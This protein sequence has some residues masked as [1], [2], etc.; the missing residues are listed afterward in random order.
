MADA[1]MARRA[2]RVNARKARAAQ[3]GRRPAMWGGR[4][5]RRSDIDAAVP[6]RTGSVT[7]QRR[8]PVRRPVAKKAVSTT[9]KVV[10]PKA[11]T[12][13]LTVVRAATRKG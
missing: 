4:R 12:A 9:A 1:V 8:A 7:G 10:A 2:E 6:Q 13:G 3:T 11:V 5:A